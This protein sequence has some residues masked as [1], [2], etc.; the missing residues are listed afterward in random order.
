MGAAGPNIKKFAQIQSLLLKHRGLPLIL[1]GDWNMTPLALQASGF[2]RPIKGAIKTPEVESTC[3]SGRLI[4]FA[5][6]SENF[7]PAVVSLAVV[8]ESPWKAHA[9]LQLEVA[10]APRSINIRKAWKPMQFLPRV[11]AAAPPGR[12]WQDDRFCIFPIATDAD[13]AE[14]RPKQVARN[15]SNMSAQSLLERAPLDL[16]ATPL[17]GVKNDS[18]EVGSLYG[19]WSQKWEKHLTKKFLGKRAQAEAASYRGRGDMPTFN[20]APL[21]GPRDHRNT[22]TK[23]KEEM[24]WLSLSGRLTDLLR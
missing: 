3:W 4:D 11:S 14:K 21:L 20:W 19:R 9:L 5:V 7:L 12:S 1:F 16:S 24:W 13:A 18:D 23:Q 8:Q 17:A 2:L 22:S 15:T 10:A 6:V